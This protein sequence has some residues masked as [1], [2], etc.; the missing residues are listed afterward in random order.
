MIVIVMFMIR[1]C[2]IKP[3]FLDFE[4]TISCNI[5]MS[6]SF[7]SLLQMSDKILDSLQAVWKHSL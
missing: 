1:M 2:G 5:W 4:V 3:S 6:Q 7:H